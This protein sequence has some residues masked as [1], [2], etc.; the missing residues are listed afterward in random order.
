[1]RTMKWAV[2]F[3]VFSAA[4]TNIAMS[5][6]SLVSYFCP[7]RVSRSDDD[8]SSVSGDEKEAIHDVASPL[9]TVNVMDE[10]RR[11]SNLNFE[12]ADANFAG[13][14]DA[15]ETVFDWKV[16]TIVDEPALAKNG[17]RLENIGFPYHFRAGGVSRRSSLRFMFDAGGLAYFVDGNKR[18]VVTT[19]P[20]ARVKWLSQLR[21]PEPR[22]LV[23]GS[24]ND[25][26]EAAFAAGFW[27]LDPEVWVQLLVNALEDTDRDVRFD[28]AYALGEC[29]PL[30]KSAI[31]P[32]CALLRSDDL[33]LR[34]AATFALG[35]IGSEASLR[36]LE[37][38]DDPDRS[39]ALS[40]LKAFGV[41]GSGGNEAVTGMM[42]AAKRYADPKK[43]LS[44]DEYCG[45]SHAIGSALSEV[46]LG[47]AVPLLRDLLNSDSAR[48]RSFAAF[49]IGEIGPRGQVCEPEL[50]KLLSDDSTSVR[51]D[52]AYAMARIDL[53]SDTSTTALEAAANDPDYDVTLW[54]TA[55]LR[56]IRSKK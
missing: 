41:M 48:I 53:P 31:D 44:D 54:A 50:Q 30:A 24:L 28:S 56:V 2:V 20:L 8:N 34:E 22:D 29:G 23:A 37:L 10:L 17:I 35:R 49:A 14:L 27:H 12:G 1:M 55:A 13:L 36:L 52:A 45:L 39:I 11:P 26:R 21:K 6:N 5:A 46:E 42:A 15:L 51:R 3:V 40:A 7:M 9:D 16:K 43:S 33:T 47:D 32:L 4:F 19:K 18:L 25:R 38:I